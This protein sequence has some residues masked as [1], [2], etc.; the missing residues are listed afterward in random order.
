MLLMA[1]TA[2]IEINSVCI[3]IF[4]RQIG[5]SA[6]NAFLHDVG[7]NAMPASHQ[8]HAKIS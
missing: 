5:L 2:T 3:P 4:S 8:D 1:I 7:A 6:P